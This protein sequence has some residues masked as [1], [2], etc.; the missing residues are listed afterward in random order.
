MKKRYVIWDE[1]SDI[2]TPTGK[3]FTAEQWLERYPIAKLETEHL[4]ISGSAYNGGFC[5]V[6][7][8]MVDI[9][10]R[11]GCDFTGCTEQQDFLDVIEAFEDARN[12]EAATAVST[13]ERIAAALEL[14]CLQ[15]MPDVEE[16]T[17]EETTTETEEA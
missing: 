15:N 7:S 13:E 17:T 4:V 10:E 2:Y 12:A 3:K 14:Q 11:E 8:D 16:E 6:F 9:Y 1:S 5:M